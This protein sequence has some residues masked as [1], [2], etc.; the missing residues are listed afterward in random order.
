MSNLLILTLLLIPPRHLQM[1]TMLRLRNMRL[2]KH[3]LH[4][5]RSLRLIHTS[6]Q[7][8]H[9]LQTSALGL[10]DEESYEY[11]HGET[12]DAEHEECA[13]A[14]VVDGIWG[15]FRDDEVEEPLG[16]S[17]EADA[18]CAETGWEDLLF[19]VSQ[20]SPDIEGMEKRGKGGKGIPR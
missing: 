3:L 20:L 1:L 14:D 19:S 4:I 9:I 11:A 5:C 7:D 8:I 12:E 18:V 16:C 17:G 6:K 13:P 15:D 2:V 10:L